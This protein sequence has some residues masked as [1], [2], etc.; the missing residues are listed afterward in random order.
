MTFWGWSR[1]GNSLDQNLKVLKQFAISKNYARM[2][3]LLVDYSQEIFKLFQKKKKYSLT[4]FFK[5][6]YYICRFMRKL[7]K[8]K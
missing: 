8:N 5:L 6:I 3:F 4:K 2:N 1:F 7:R